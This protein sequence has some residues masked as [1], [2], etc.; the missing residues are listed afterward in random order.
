[1]K[2]SIDLDPKQ[3]EQLRA[4]ADRLNVSVETLAAAA[5]RELLDDR[6]EDFDTVAE[7]VLSKNRDLYRRLA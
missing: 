7:R 2:L 4:I 5:L 6:V 3:E 1:M